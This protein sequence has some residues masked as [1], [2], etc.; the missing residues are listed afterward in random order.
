MCG[1]GVNQAVWVAASHERRDAPRPPPQP[2]PPLLA[3]AAAT[4]AGTATAA[5]IAPKGAGS[6]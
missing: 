4:A 3:T 1:T 5:P 2:P 6:S